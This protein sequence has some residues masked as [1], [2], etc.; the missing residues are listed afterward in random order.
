MES[1][2][3]D[4]FNVEQTGGGCTAWVRHITETQSCYITSAYGDNFEE[5]EDE[6]YAVGIYD[7][8]DQLAYQKVKT[9]D[10]A[11]AV[12]NG[13]FRERGIYPYWISSIDRCPKC[14]GLTE[15]RIDI[16]PGDGYEVNIAERCVVCG[17]EATW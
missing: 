9:L 2:T 12:A 14:K 6:G 13:W 16:D 5:Y 11:F 8:G 17:W 1:K 7:N 3:I 10:D 4:G 15:I